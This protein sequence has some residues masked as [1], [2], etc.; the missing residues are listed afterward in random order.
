MGNERVKRVEYKVSVVDFDIG[1][2]QGQT[3][4]LWS[5]LKKENLVFAS[6][7]GEKR[8][9]MRT[10]GEISVTGASRLHAAS[11]F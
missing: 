3:Q 11:R 4:G 9:I 1:C 10:G 8:L 7:V 2:D 6:R 5:G